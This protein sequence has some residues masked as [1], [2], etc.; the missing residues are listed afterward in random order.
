MG[1][2]V[3]PDVIDR[4]AARD[5]FRG[6]GV[7]DALAGAGPEVAALLLEAAD[8]IADSFGTEPQLV[9]EL[10]VFLDDDDEPGKLYGLIQ[11]TLEPAEAEPIMDRWLRDWWLEEWRRAR[12]R[13]NFG[14]EYV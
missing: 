14:L 11:T 8:R 2:T 12:C 5:R 6:D 7:A 9:L 1:S 10:L 3:A 13:L 4:I